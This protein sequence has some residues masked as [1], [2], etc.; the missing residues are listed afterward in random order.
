MSNKYDSIIFDLDG[1]L[2]DTVDCVVEIWNAALVKAGIEPTLNYDELSRCMGLRIGQIFDRVIPQATAGQRSLIQETIAGT[3]QAILAKKGG[4]LYGKVEET[5]AA[6]MKTHRLFI[7]SNCQE[8][9]INA[10]FEAHDMRKYFEDYECAGRTGKSKGEN[11]RLLAERC[12][13]ERPVYIGDTVYDYE[14]TTEA[15]VPFIHA[16]YGFG[17]VD[18][19]VK[20]NSFEEIPK[21]V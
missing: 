3:E 15:G 9:Y 21:L 18:C 8:G 10:F 5:L 14:A 12:G 20:A 4:I 1:T 11:I 16:A 7:I 13:L 17:K 2:W 19:E 6:L